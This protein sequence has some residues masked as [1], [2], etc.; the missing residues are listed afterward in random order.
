MNLKLRGVSHEYR[1]KF[2]RLEKKWPGII[3]PDIIINENGTQE[4]GPALLSG[5]T[6]PYH[7]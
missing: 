3:K 5:T 6:R 4:A 2:A 1:E 7:M